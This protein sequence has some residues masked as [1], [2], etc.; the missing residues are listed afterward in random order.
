M[1]ASDRSIEAVTFDFWNTLIA[2]DVDPWKWKTDAFLA[3]ATDAGHPVDRAD[4]RGALDEGKR[5]YQQA[6][7][8]GEVFTPEQWSEVVGRQLGIAEDSRLIAVFASILHEGLPAERRELT[9]GTAE[10]LPALAEAGFRLGIICDVGLTPS[11]RLRSYLEHFGVLRYF[12]HWS[13]SDEVG[14]FKPDRRIFEHAAEG[15]GVPF[16][17]ILHTGD[18]RRTDITGGRAAGMTTARY[19]GAA[20]DLSDGP[21]GDHVT[22]DH[23]ELLQILGL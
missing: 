9:P 18:L 19:R 15:L 21:E 3:A 16:D 1:V 12:D 4:M 23:R 22:S 11:T 17:R 13:F 5:F 2:E 20:D 6:W 10:A 8:R 14:V 7:E